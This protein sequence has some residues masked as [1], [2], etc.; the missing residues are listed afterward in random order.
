M[1]RAMF[2]KEFTASWRS[3]KLIA[4]L[5]VFA[6]LGIMSPFLALFTPQILE[7]ALQDQLP[8]FTIP[9]PTA[10]DSFTQLFSNIN[11]MG[12]IIFVIVFG[13]ILTSEFSSGTLINLLTKGLRRDVVI[14]VKAVFVML[15]WTIVYAIAALLAYLY[16]IYYWDEPLHQL[17]GALFTPWLFGIFLISV[18]FLSSVLFRNFI[19]VLSSVVIVV[20]ICYLLSIHPSLSEWLP[21]YLIGHNIEMLM[22]KKPFDEMWPAIGVTI[23]LHTLFFVLTIVRFRK[24]EV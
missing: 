8:G 7:S 9:E 12:L 2:Q 6:T 17:F 16:T 11:Q 21:T 20:I 22:D 14:H 19:G 3:F 10:Y 23:G 13:S 4:L 1:F 15:V 5:I 18:I 24:M